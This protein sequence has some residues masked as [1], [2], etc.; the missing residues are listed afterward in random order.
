MVAVSDTSPISN[1][2]FIGRL[3]LLIAQFE[4]VCIP[5][6]VRAELERMPKLEAKC[7]IEQAGLP[8][9]GVL[10]ILIRAKA[11]AEIDSLRAEMEALRSR[12]GFFVAPSLEAEVLRNVG[13]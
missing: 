1:P 7:S 6:A 4:E 8:V 13:E 2:A 3:D 11:K 5:E 12:A 9:R 10:G